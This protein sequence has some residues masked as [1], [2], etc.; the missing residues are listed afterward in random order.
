M[1][2]KSYPARSRRRLARAAVDALEPRQLFAVTSPVIDLLVAYTPA[3]ATSVGGSTAVLQRVTRAVADANMIL[4]NSKVDASIRLVGLTQVD[5]TETT[6]DLPTDLDRLR[7]PSDGYADSIHA[8]RD[9]AGADVVHLL[10]SDGGADAGFA[11]RP[12]DPAVSYADYGFAVSA[13]QYATT[14]YVFAHEVMHVLGAAHADGEDPVPSQLPYAHGYRFTAG[15][16]EISTVTAN[17]KRI[18]YLGGPDQTWRGYTLGVAD[19]SDD[20]RAVRQFVPGVAAYRATR[21]NDFATPQAA[22]QQVS[23]AGG[24]TLTVEVKLADDN[25]VDVGTLGYGDVRVTGPNGFS[26]LATFAGVDRNSSGGQRVA[27]YTVDVTG[28]TND[29]TQYT[30]AVVANQIADTAGKFVPAGTLAR[31]V[32]AATYAD[33]AGPDMANAMELGDVGNTRR[34]ITDGITVVDRSNHYRFTIGSNATVTAKL[35]GL[36]ANAN[37]YLIQDKNSNGIGNLGEYLYQGQNSGTADE[38]VTLTLAAG[39]YDLNVFPVGPSTTTPYV[40]TLQ[41]VGGTN[42]TATT[43]GLSGTFWRDDNGNGVKDTG[44]AGLANWQAWVDL[45]GDGVRETT[46]RTVT[47]DANGFYSVTGLAP[48][49]YIVRPIAQTGY[50][51]SSS[52][53]SYSVSVTAGV[54][55]TGKNF[56]YTTR[57]LVSGSL[58]LD[59]NKN[60]VRDSGELGLS[61]WTVFLDKDGDGVLDADEKRATTDASGNWSI[62][63]ALPGTYIIRP[64]IKSGYAMS[65]STI[66]VTLSAAQTVTGKSLGVKTV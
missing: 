51:R 48:K 11:Y 22:L 28:S 32:S 50:R 38:S 63:D 56:G 42:P 13:A 61:G 40:L 60:K 39:S 34:A 9:A 18:P 17:A 65:T 49:S 62:K 45:D 36:T 4:A 66:S 57:A 3:A 46:D 25:G 55:A 1:P 5:Y 54:T 16:Q 41:V 31:A 12:D 2:S 30:A 37:L 47:T 29:P 58:W 53:A 44:E 21:Y 14:D 10:V 6:N 7:N 8:S 59:S 19:V 24:K 33:R 26:K 27:R 64:V 15:A 52:A 20:A 43:G 23:V 35:T